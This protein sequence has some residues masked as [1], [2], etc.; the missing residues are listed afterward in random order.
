MKFITILRWHSASAPALPRALQ[1]CLAEDCRVSR[2]IERQ[3]SGYD[4]LL[5][6]EG[7]SPR[8]LDV[9]YRQFSEQATLASYLVEECVERDS[10]ALATGTGPHGRKLVTCW[11]A[12]ADLTSAQAR[13]R[14]D[15]HVPLARRIHVGCQRYVRNWVLALVRASGDFPPIYSGFAFQYF[16]SARDLAERLFDSPESAGVIQHDVAAFI[17]TF[18]VQVCTD[19]LHGTSRAS[20][21]NDT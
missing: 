4:L 16:A 21:G 2:P 15:E 1:W 12:R 7:G 13:Q 19:W 6:Q 5:E 14:W 11:R 18:E 20:V 9:L 8:V 17:D 3:D 10:P